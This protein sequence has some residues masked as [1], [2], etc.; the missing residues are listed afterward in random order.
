MPAPGHGRRRWRSGHPDGSD[1]RHV[2]QGPCLAAGA[3]TLAAGDDADRQRR[4]TLTGGR[5]TPGPSPPREHQPG[6]DVR[7]RDGHAAD[8]RVRRP[9]VHRR[10]HDG[11]R[12]PA[13]R[14]HRQA[15]RHAQ[16]GR[17][18]PDRAT[19][20]RTPPGR[21]TRAARRSSSPAARSPAATTST[22][23]SSGRRPRP[24]RRDDVTVGGTLSYAGALNGTGTLAALG[25][26]SQ[27]VGVR[28][29]D[30]H[31]ADRRRPPPR[32]SPA[33]PPRPPATCPAWSS[34]SRRHAHPGRHDPDGE[35]LDV[36]RRNGRPG[37]LD[38]GLRGGTITGSH[39]LNGVDFRR[40][41]TRS[42]PGTTLTV[43]GR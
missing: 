34:T 5:S 39:A 11:R 35:R 19:A 10:R 37:R 25:P 8:Q 18:D 24:G 30:G 42:P 7:Q 3:K 4:L 17:H 14:R 31:A 12:Q 41:R 36:H 33:P 6:L 21:S 27:A 28:R 22:T 20:G 15:V 23:S 40:R 1:R 43:G 16:P 13:R 9:D 32:R 26:I 2:Q 29:R 38:G